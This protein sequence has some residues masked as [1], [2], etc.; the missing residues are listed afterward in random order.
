[1]KII[2]ISR[3]AVGR[4]RLANGAFATGFLAF[5]IVTVGLANLGEGQWVL[6]LF[7]FAVA[8]VL[9]FAAREMRRGSRV[10]SLI[11][12]VI[13]AAFL[14]LGVA[15]GLSVIHVVLLLL[16]VFFVVQGIRG[17]F[18]LGVVR[19]N[20]QGKAGFTPKVSYKPRQPMIV[21]G[22]LA[23]AAL[24]LLGGVV[25][26]AR[27]VLERFV[28]TLGELFPPR[29]DIQFLLTM[30]GLGLL[31]LSSWS[32]T[33]ARRHLAASVSEIRARDSRAPILLLRSFGDDMIGV[34]EGYRPSFGR[35]RSKSFEE[36]LTEHLWEI[37]P[38]IAIGRP[39]ESLPRLGAAREYISNQDWQARMAEMA[40]SAQRI[41]LIVG[42]TDGILWEIRKLLSTGFLGR[43]I[44]VFPPILPE[45][46]RNRWEA[47]SKELGMGDACAV[48]V[49]QT[50]LLAFPTASESI[51]VV[52]K[53]KRGNYYQE[54][55]RFAAGNGK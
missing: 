22:L 20:L 33:R 30:T 18:A 3:A 43:T 14:L 35:R 24:A 10:A 48:P 7:F 1:M 38:V 21:T 39:G 31:S 19:K 13:L 8:V 55:L 54:A 47:V 12:G 17:A 11:S 26:I 27:S 23:L 44:L 46:L 6:P 2:D 29:L 50:L 42:R 36:V 51:C 52:G 32:F 5:I 37:G 4:M 28:P 9:V 15:G 25:L 16:L 40:A 45:E 53:R 49:D 34:F 41:V